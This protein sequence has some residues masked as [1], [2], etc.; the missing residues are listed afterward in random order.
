MTMKNYKELPNED[1]ITAVMEG[2]F[3]SDERALPNNT[4]KP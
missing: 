4:L 2:R 3:M 1:K